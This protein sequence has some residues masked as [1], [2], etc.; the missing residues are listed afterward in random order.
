MSRKSE[1]DLGS[2]M[3]ARPATFVVAVTGGIASGKSAVTTRLAS[4]GVPVFDADEVTRELCAPGQPALEEIRRRFGESVISAEGTLDRRSLRAMVFADP[5]ERLALE[6][7]LHPRVRARLAE[8]A[9][10]VS[11]DYCVLAIPLLAEGNR[12]AW[13]DRVV[14]VD[15]PES[16]RIERLIKRDGIDA[17]LAKRMIASQADRDRRLAIADDIL[18]NDGTLDALL[19][20]TDALHRRLTALAE[21]HRR[22]MA[23]EGT[24]NF[25]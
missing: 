24:R 19:A 5:A 15:A 23:T 2:E 1:T 14:V 18:E 13:I 20:A 21:D 8:L 6:A 10:A 11:G 16:T 22:R 7:I 3:W 25:P 9:Q 12:Y 17:E 4:L